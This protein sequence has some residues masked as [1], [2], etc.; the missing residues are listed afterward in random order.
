MNMTL[1]HS[2]YPG[3]T[4]FAIATNRNGV[5]TESFDWWNIRTYVMGLRK[6]K[7][8]WSWRKGL[9]KSYTNLTNA[10]MQKI[11]NYAERF[12]GV[13]Y[14]LDATFAIAKLVAPKKFTC[15]TL[16]WYSIKKTHGID[17]SAWWNPL[18]VTPSD[19]Y[20]SSN[21]YVITELR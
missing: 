16:L 14:C 2:N 21:T 13:P 18:L 4:K 5:T 19:I 9:T 17:V 11:A 1:S 12:Y 20:N 3:S 6:E 7:W 10:Q 8:T 15:T